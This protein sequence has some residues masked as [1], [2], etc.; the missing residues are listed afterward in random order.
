[1]RVAFYML[2]VLA[3]CSGDT[4]LPI[5]AECNPLGVNHCMTPWPSSA[6]EVEDATTPTGRHLALPEGTLPTNVGNISIDP[7]GWNVA[8]GFSPAAPIVMS[9]DGSVSA[10][11]LPPRDHMDL[12][13]AQTSPTVILDMTTGLRVAHFAEIDPSD[14]TL[15]SQAIVLRPAR[16][17]IGGHRYAVA[18]TN[19][20]KDRDGED[21]AVPP[22]FAAL[23]DGHDTDHALL[24][25]MRPRFQEVLDALEVDGCPDSELVVAWDFTVASDRR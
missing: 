25:D 12:S 22:G 23:R 2:V 4:A 15:D 14:G 8:D 17:L 6:F 9:F 7:A 13:L 21:L 5:Q 10:N 16:R 3:A 18:I 11:G 19:L 1:M 20:V 24:E